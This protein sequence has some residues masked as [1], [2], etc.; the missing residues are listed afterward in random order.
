MLYEPD[1]F[2]MKVSDCLAFSASLSLATALTVLDL[3]CNLLDDK[4]VTSSSSPPLCTLNMNGFHYFEF[5]GTSFLCRSKF[6]W[7]GCC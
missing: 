2:G 1:K 4:K 3:S 7:R 6:Y 5:G